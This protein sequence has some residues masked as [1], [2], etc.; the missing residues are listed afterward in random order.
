MG[1]TLYLLDGHAQIFRAYYAPF[2]PLTSPA[3][4][5]TKAVHVFFQMLLT[6]ARDKKPDYLAVTLDTDD[7][8][9]FRTEIY[10]KYK[11]NRDETPEDLIPQMRRIVQVLEAARIPILQLSG[12]EAD[13]IMAT[14]CERLAGRDVE[15]F[16]V[17]KDKDLEQLLRPGVA[18]YDP[19]KDSVLTAEGLVEAKGYPPE[20]SIEV[21]TLIG[22]SIDN[23][24]G[25]VG[26]GP[27]KA[28]QLI[29]RYGT[30]EAVV[31]HA[32]EL[33][34]K[35][36]ENVLA[37]RDQ[38][39]L[40][41][42]LVTLR[43][44]V[45][46]AVELDAWRF[47][48]FRSSDVVPI[49]RE[50]GFSRLTEQYAAAA[51]PDD[52]V[53]ETGAASQAATVP[54][55]LLPPPSDPAKTAERYRLVDTPQKL[56][57][58]ARDL[59]RQK[60]F[61]F[62]TETTGL[63]PV[64]SDL[65]GLSF[66]WQA[67]SGYYLPVRS[68]FGSVLALDDIRREIGPVL[69][70]PEAEKIGQNVKY[71]LLALRAAGIAVR[72]V[73]FDCMIASFVLD[74]T[75]RSHGMDF[76][77]ESLLGYKPI[78]ITDLIGRGSDQITL[79]QVDVNRVCEYA[80]E[81]ADVTWRL[82]E[83]LRPQI[84]AAPSCRLFHETEMPLVEVLAEMEWNGVSLDTK[85]LGEMSRE[86]TS[87][88]MELTRRVHE[89]AG[90]PF[91]IDSPKQLGEVLFDE[92]K[93]RVI[94]KTKTARS[95]D[96]ETL[97]TLAA[98]TDHPLPGLVLEYRELTKLKSTYIDALPT[99]I[100]ARTGRVHASFHQ[101]GA[102][103]GRLSSSDPNL[104]NIPIRTE[105][106][107]RIR[108]AFVPGSAEQVLLAADYSQVELRILAHFSEDEALRA[109]FAEDQDIHRFVAGQVFGVRTE[110]VTAEQR[111]RAKAVNFGIVYGQTAYGLSRQTGMPVG[112]AQG[113][114][115]TYFRRYPGIQRFIRATIEQA[116]RDNY[117]E[118]ILGRR[119]AIEGLHSRNKQLAAQAE[120]FA[121]NT[122]I[123]GSAADLIKR[124]MIHI[125]RRIQ[126][127]QRPT[128]M[129]IQ[130]HDELVFEV[131]RKHAEAE[132]EMIRGEMVSALPLSVPLKV[133]LKWGDNW[134]EVK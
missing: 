105:L 83:V 11:A 114:I 4:E 63:N 87:R 66:S 18:L 117:V 110:D 69:G 56:A 13:D 131:L 80:A 25:V 59:R 101:T 20:K 41:R 64:S 94:H 37:I 34:P 109:A 33:T 79:D 132:A 17:S 30:A 134:Y 108:K 24:P 71:D 21:Q 50:L 99:F 82:W 119:R 44:D 35:M 62:D 74:S 5:P 40:T 60:R 61:A 125:H 70:D 92:L 3:G 128:K 88:M 73:T 48:G 122:V 115:D 1:E 46:I 45:P 85:L 93:F 104:Q 124:S 113:F 86:L 38:M 91:N 120:R 51:S 111:S 16:L 121:V 98:E 65:V 23:I 57:D 84:D 102:V 76:L 8:T 129:L 42:R 107:R 43:R 81:D 78:P 77:A 47:S 10:P 89:A 28:A 95:T 116:R 90:R 2:P 15:V 97:E 103:T 14:V 118:T 22:D 9:V 12:F 32:D 96:A 72:G 39:A 123:Q 31:E 26:V 67:G 127:E 106:G 58:F 27:K 75:R 112:E 100:N 49:F 130:V 6:L 29:A 68:M 54:E 53:D 126:R 36:R 19:G 7:R 55:T 52:A 133:D